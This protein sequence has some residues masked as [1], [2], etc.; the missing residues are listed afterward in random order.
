MIRLEQSAFDAALL[1]PT[2]CRAAT[3]LCAIVAALQRAQGEQFTRENEEG[4]RSAFE[5]RAMLGLTA[6]P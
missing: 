4:Y 2:T 1:L 5:V 6:Q 3:I